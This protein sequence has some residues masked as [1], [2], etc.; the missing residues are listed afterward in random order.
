MLDI[1]LSD[2]G[3]TVTTASNGAEALEQV[4]ADPPAIVLLDV[5]MPVLDGWQT[6]ARLQAHEQPIPVIMMSA[7]KNYDETADGFGVPCLAKP[8][9]LD[10]LIGLV[11]RITALPPQRP[12]LPRIAR[13]GARGMRSLR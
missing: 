8:F 3:Y 10:A 9:D 4:L 11:G 7:A 5:M 2:E 12:S 6:L 1:V 13:P